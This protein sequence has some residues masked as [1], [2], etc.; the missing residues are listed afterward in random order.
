MEFNMAGSD[1]T[2]VCQHLQRGQFLFRA[3]SAQLQILYVLDQGKE[4]PHR[5]VL[6]Y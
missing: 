3:H 6:P 4:G 1:D 5:L 2:A